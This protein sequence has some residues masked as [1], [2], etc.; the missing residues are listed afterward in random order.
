MRLLDLRLWGCLQLQLD[1]P[2][3]TRESDP[4]HLTQVLIIL[5]ALV[6]IGKGILGLLRLQHA[7]EDVDL[8]TLVIGICLFQHSVEY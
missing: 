4:Q 2:L 8:L 1:L 5:A 6:L 7:P 3:Q